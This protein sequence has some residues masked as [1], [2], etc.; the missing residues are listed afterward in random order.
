MNR[1]YIN[2]TV[3]GNTISLA[4]PDQIH[5]LREVLRLKP[6]DEIMVFDEA[7]NEFLT[8]ISGWERKQ[9]I[10]TIISRKPAR[11]DRL[12][13]AIA[14]AVPKKSRMDDIIDKLTQLGVDT[15]IPLETE[16]VIVKM[17]EN[18]ISRLERWRKIARNAAE[19][20]QRNRLTEVTP[21]TALEDVL[22][23]A[24]DFDL[25]LL[26]TLTGE[27]RPIRDVLAGIRP[28]SI[29]ALIGPEGDF[30]PREIEQASI[31]GF[32]SVSLGSTVLRVETAAI[33]LAAY[34]HLALG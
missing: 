18:K 23:Q 27:S 24:V 4:D 21:V 26:P 19:Q 1:V 11:P 15:I 10:L 9:A 17:E 25:K 14:C 5:H 30:S 22:G 32:V 29:L 16:R 12:K 28:A 33:A 7:G 31:A 3:T 6:G 13:I 20:S 34:L 8:A 2:G